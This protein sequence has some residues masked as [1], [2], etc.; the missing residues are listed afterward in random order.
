MLDADALITVEIFVVSANCPSNEGT[1]EALQIA[2]I[3]FNNL[4][5]IGMCIY[6]VAGP[7]TS[8]YPV[9]W[10]AGIRGSRTCFSQTSIIAPP[11]LIKYG[12]IPSFPHNMVFK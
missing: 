3:Q 8:F 6:K 5:I 9:S 2:S 10:L 7:M 12:V 1:G 11:R 4:D